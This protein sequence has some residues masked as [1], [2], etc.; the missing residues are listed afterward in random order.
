LEK[1]IPKKPVMV[2]GQ[3]NKKFSFP[4]FFVPSSENNE[5]FFAEKALPQAA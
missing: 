4:E 3:C 1:T 5:S 2:V